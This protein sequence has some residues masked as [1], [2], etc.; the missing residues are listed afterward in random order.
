MKAKATFVT[1]ATECKQRLGAGWQK[2]VPGIIVSVDKRPAGPG[3]TKRQTYITAK[4]QFPFGHEKVV[5]IHGTKVKEAPEGDAVHAF[6]ACDLA[7]GRP[8]AS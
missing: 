2:G 7:I 3:K 1:H 6:V 4:Y 8:A 5:E